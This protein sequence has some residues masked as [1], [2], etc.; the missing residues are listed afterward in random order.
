[1]L[2]LSLTLSLTL[3]LTLFSQNKYFL[4]SRACK[5]SPL[6]TVMVVLQSPFDDYRISDLG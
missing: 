4:D 3:K 2:T 5:A 1:M 6:I